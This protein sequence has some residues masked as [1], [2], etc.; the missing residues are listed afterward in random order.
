MNKQ[1]ILALT[2]DG[3]KE[4]LVELNL[5][6]AGT[7]T[8]LRERLL[9]HFAIETG[10]DFQNDSDGNDSVYSA[11]N[12]SQNVLAGR[13]SIF[14]LRDI[15]DSVS[16]FSGEGLPEI[17]IWVQEFEDCAATVNWS[18]VQKFIYAKQ[19]L[20]GAARIF[21]RSQ[22]NIKTWD[23]LKECLSEE[24]GRKLSSLQVHKLL[25]NRKKRGNESLKEYLYSL[26]EIGNQIRLDDES[27][28]E[29]FVE[30]I[31]DSRTNKTLLYQA[32]NIKELKEKLR[33]Y[34]KISQVGRSTNNSTGFSQSKGSINKNVEKND[35]RKVRKCYKCGD[36]SHLANECVSKEI[37]CYRCKQVGHKSFDCKV[38]VKKENSNEDRK[39]SGGNVHTLTSDNISDR[40]ISSNRVFKDILINGK[41]ISAIV[42]TGSDICAITRDVLLL[43]NDVELSKETKTLVGIGDKDITTIGSFT[44]DVDLDGVVLPITFHVAKEGDILY[45]AVIG[46]DIFQY[47]DMV[48][49]KDGATFTKKS[50][51]NVNNGS[52]ESSSDNIAKK[53]DD[54]TA[55]FE[56][57]AKNVES[58]MEQ[59][60]LKIMGAM[61]LGN[62]DSLELDFEGLSEEYKKLIL[63]FVA[64]YEPKKPDFY[65]VKMKIVLADETPVSHRPRRLSIPDQEIVDR[66]VNE[67]LRD[68]IVKVSY[69]EFSSPV[70]LVG[71]KDGSKRL[72]CDYRKLNEKM[73][74]D[75][76][77]MALIDEVVQ[78]LQ[79]AKI[80]TTLDL[81]NGFFHVPIEPESQKYTSFVTPKGQ[82]EFLFVPFGIKNSPA[83]FC[84]YISSIFR[85]LVNDRTVIIY[86]D[87]I[88]IPSLTVEEGIEK[89]VKVLKVCET[90]GLKI[91]WE[92]CQFLK[93]KISFLGY[94]IENSSILPSVSKTKAVENFPLPVNQKCVQRFL[95][96]TSYFRRFVPD[97]A[98]IAKPISDLLRK[99]VEFQMGDEQILAFKQLKSALVNAPVLKLF[100]PGAL[101]EIHTDASMYGYGAVLLQ[102]DQCD[103]QLH[104][105]EYLSRK[106]TL[107]EQKYTSY[108]L[109]VLAVIEALRKWRVYIMGIKFKIVTDCNAFA[110][111][112]KKNDIPVRVSRWALFLQEFEYEIEHRSGTKMR[113]VDALSRVSCLMMEDSLR[114][115]IK[116]AQVQD[117][118]IKA[119]RKALENG[120][121]ADYFIKYGILYKNP[122]KELIVIPSAMEKEIIELTHRQGHFAAKKTVDLL[123]KNFYIP[124]AH[125]K[126][127]KI[128]RNC[129]PCI[130]SEAK[131]GR[132]EGFLCPID[133]SDKPLVVY[134]LDHVGPMEVTHKQYNHILVVVDG[135]TKFVWLYP[136]KSTG[137]S[138]VIDRLSKQASIFGNPEL[139]I[140][141]RGTAFTSREFEEYCVTEN[142]QHL[143]IATGVPR[144]NGQVE[145]MHRILVP[146]LA[147][148]CIENPQNWYRHVNKVQQIIN[149]TATRSTK[150]SPF[151]LLT[152]VDMR[153]KDYPDLRRMVEDE[154][155]SELTDR[156]ESERLEARQNILKLQ[157]ENCKTFNKKRIPEIKY[158][159]ND[160]VAIKRTQ[161]GSGLKLRPKFHGPYKV[162]TCR[163]HGRYEVEKVGSSEGPTKTSTVAEYMKPWSGHSGRM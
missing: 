50:V 117:E 47:V 144:G 28:I 100:I 43:L 36:N 161:Y 88:V 116:G 13:G 20:K 134:H 12:S 30:G 102:V 140:T 6:R 11:A 38:N 54:D 115:Q 69:S 151:R 67:W 26:Q 96:L 77:P 97:Y 42:D 57:S 138:E 132:K 89:L 157:Q 40:L 111:T 109:E 154:I 110:M 41:E 64:Q 119:V 3:L 44:V 56:Q 93:R 78:K 51:S 2:V 55:C 15:S 108:E 84:R 160:L 24:F 122:D 21:I 81:R 105:V 123:E 31:P 156:R 131:R 126:V 112:M 14:T 92:K 94:E 101:T 19:L 75:N 83:V 141:D 148:L 76:Y 73:V 149:S 22:P 49:A 4:K 80:Y 70:V 155:L 125:S 85:G 129:V 74:R 124:D 35:D 5:S 48:I 34:E 8:V 159:V 37:R 62:N 145:R 82:Y 121:Y 60:F 91:K 107:A 137:S 18:S 65:P 113:H 33:A 147:K 99:G 46:N 63:S 136:T 98:M 104:P 120:P 16:H 158:K 103:Q 153:N 58:E 32:T 59:D 25:R 52:V 23:S 10:E 71:K 29:Y 143:L 118:W 61:V 135:F 39:A 142:V 152:G 114:H 106:T 86:M 128:I 150:F 45:S 163:K 87:D 68:G 95:G 17:G 127:D 7:K 27:L 130:V 9:S 1:E 72:C 146:M 53:P 90:N 162:V 66:Q 139:V 133:K 79:E